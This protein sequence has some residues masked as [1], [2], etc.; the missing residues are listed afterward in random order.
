MGNIFIDRANDP[1]L[2]NTEYAKIKQI[3][4]IDADY[5]FFTIGDTYLKNPTNVPFGSND[6]TSKERKTQEGKMVLLTQQILLDYMKDLLVHILPIIDLFYRENGKNIADNFTKGF[7]YT[8]FYRSSAV[9]A[10][11]ER[12]A[13]NSPHLLGRAID[14]FMNG[15]FRG[16]VSARHQMAKLLPFAKQM[17]EKNKGKMYRFIVYFNE[18]G[19]Q[20][21]NLIDNESTKQLYGKIM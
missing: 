16:G 9:N 12:A 2:T 19:S 10:G 17:A 15:T 18:L 3:Y 5:S 13:V 21:G 14:V 4:G 20:T 6:D 11:N 7:D 8:S 1:I